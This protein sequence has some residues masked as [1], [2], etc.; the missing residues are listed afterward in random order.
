M[1][2]FIVYYNN[3]VIEASDSLNSTF[4]HLIEVGVVK[5]VIDITELKVWG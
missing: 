2:K 1:K 3:G 5:S 4:L